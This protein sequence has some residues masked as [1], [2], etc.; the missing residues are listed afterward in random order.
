MMGVSGAVVALLSIVV[1]AIVAMS[2]RGIGSRSR[3][4]GLLVPYVHRSEKA[5]TSGHRAALISVAPACLLSLSCGIGSMIFSDAK[6][7]GLGWSIWCGGL[8]IGAL[9]AMVTARSVS[10]N[11]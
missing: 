10:P 6:L 4:V 9:L 3:T 5:W 11:R 8:V 7:A 2:A 1:F